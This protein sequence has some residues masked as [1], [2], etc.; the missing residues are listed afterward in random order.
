MQALFRTRWVIHNLAS[1]D[2]VFK[3]INKIFIRLLYFTLF[4]PPKVF[5]GK[6]YFV[7]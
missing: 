4:K 2:C 1:M 7:S 6:L 3:F 5:W